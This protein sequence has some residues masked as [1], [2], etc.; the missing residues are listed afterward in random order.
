[1]TIK[2]LVA[3]WQFA[4]DPVVQEAAAAAVV[5]LGILFGYL[6]KTRPGVREFAQELSDLSREVEPWVRQAEA[7][8][9]PGVDKFTEVYRRFQA[10]LKFQGI[11]GRAARV[12]RK[13]LPVFVEAAVRRVQPKARARQRQR[14]GAA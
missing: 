5:L 14:K 4:N 12:L 9:L 1:M 7:L 8:P 2:T 11:E 13:A 10:W 6:I 3:I